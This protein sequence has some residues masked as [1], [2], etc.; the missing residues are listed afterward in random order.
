[1]TTNRTSFLTILLLGILHTFL[2]AFSGTPETKQNDSIMAIGCFTNVQSHGEYAEGYAVRLWFQ[3]RQIIGL[4]NYYNGF[5]ADPPMGIL[6][7]VQYDSSTGNF[8]FKA[9]LT[10]GLHNCRIHKDVPSHDLFSFEGLLNE[11]NLEGT[12][13]FEN[14]LDPSP[15]VLDSRDNFLMLKD[16]DCLIKNYE[17][18]DAWWRFWESIYKMRG[19]KW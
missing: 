3:G 13:Y 2:V 9:K 8:S 14:Q 4:I 6:S 17:D 12:I 10:T 18:H 1:M 5:I 7:D 16:K 19:A 15:E 11:S